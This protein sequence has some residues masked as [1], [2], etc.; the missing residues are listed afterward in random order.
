MLSINVISA[1]FAHSATPH[2]ILSASTP[3][4]IIAA[5]T[6]TGNWCNA[7]SE[8]LLHQSVSA[9]F[10]KITELTGLAEAKLLQ[11]FD[12]VISTQSAIVLKAEP[13]LLPEN[14]KPS[15]P[16]N[17]FLEIYPIVENN[18]VVYLVLKLLGWAG[19]PESASIAPPG[20][21]QLLP[22]IFDSLA[23]V[24]FVLEVEAPDLYK[25][26]F[27]NRAFEVTT[28][29]PVNKVI[30]SYVQE[31]IP[32]PSLSLVLEKYREAILERKQVSWQEVSDYPAGQKTGEVLVEPVFD[33][34]GN[35]LRLVG[36]VHDI[37]ERKEAEMKQERLT[38]DLYRHNRDLQQFTYI[39][40]H[41][42]RAPLANALGL[43]KHLPAIDTN[44]ALY[45]QYLTHLKTSIQKLDTILKD[46]TLILSIRD[47]QHLGC[48]EEIALAEVCHQAGQDLAPALA[49]CDGHLNI[50]IDPDFTV[51]G[52]RA[53]WYSI[54]QNLISNAIKYRFA[55]R[56]LQ[57]TVTASVETA[58]KKVILFSDNGSGFDLKKNKNEVFK[59]YKRF[60][61]TDNI[62]GRG[63][64]LF[65]VKTHVE[66]MG[67]QIGVKSELN[68]GTTFTIYF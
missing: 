30:G 32:E 15:N 25:F 7:K 22:L 18:Q 68:V 3:Y 31:I 46:V 51:K 27:A 24:I 61:D 47:R 38:Q 62:E 34:Q 9:G 49:A 40:S 10:C 26:S 1:A 44:T 23:N 29:L 52:I 8:E 11:L 43:V 37:T 16:E 33:A 41:N 64:G 21:Q 28:G 6:A 19:K 66:A 36:M 4:P 55:D 39:V 14:N 56:L 42:L 63:I 67:G 65:L 20:T 45:Q 17:C 12:Q 50:T 48:T 58:E 54:F 57:I 60:H 53:Y 5:N 2:L 35:C 59:L 13:P